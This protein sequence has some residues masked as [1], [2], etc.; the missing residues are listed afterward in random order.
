M[1][2]LVLLLLST[3]A[4]LA[5]AATTAAGFLAENCSGCHGGDEPE[6]GFEVTGLSDAGDGDPRWESVLRRVAAGQ[7]P[8]PDAGRLDEASTARFIKQVAAA[9]GDRASRIVQAGRPPA[10]RRLTRTEYANAVRDLLAVTVDA[11]ELLPRDEESGGFDNITN[12]GLSPARVA[13]YVAAAERISRTALGRLN[14]DTDGATYRV[15]PNRTQERHVEGLPLGTRGGAVFT[16]NVPVA[17]RYAFRIRLARDR[18]EKVEGLDAV[19]ELDLLIDGRP[20]KRFTVRPPGGGG[21]WEVDFSN[22]DAHLRTETEVAAGPR[23]IGVAFVPRSD[24]LREI[25]RQPFEA[26]YNRH[27]H[28]R[29]SPALYELSVVG[30][31][32]PPTGGLADTPSRRAVF[33][34]LDPTE[35]ASYDEPEARAILSRLARLAFRRPATTDEIDRLTAFYRDGGDFEDGLGRAIAALLVN[36]NFLLRVEPQ[37]DD[38]TPGTAYPLDDFSVAARLSFFLWSSLP[39]GELLDAADAG[40]LQDAEEVSRQASRMLADPRASALV[41]NFADQ[42]LQLRNLAA[43]T[44]DLRAFPDFDDNLRRAMR[45]E[46]QLL[47]EEVV[48]EDRPVTDLIVSDHTFL[49][50][51]LATHYGIPH[52][53]GSH[54]R[55]VDLP[56]D[57][58]RG[59]LLRHAS[60][61]TVTSYATRTS[62]TIR[63]NW[64]LEHILGTPAPPPPPNVPALREKQATAA[65]TVRERL[66]QH[67][68]DPACASCHQLMDP[69]GFALEHFDAVGRH[70]PFEGDLPIDA[71]GTLPDG[72]EVAGIDDLEAAIAARPELFVT[73]LTERLM[74]Y[75]LGRVLA[76][77]D[78]PHV[79]RVVANAAANGN[80]FSA[81]VEGVVRSVPFRMRDAE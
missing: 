62:P 80:R 13:R 74:T 22:A 5:D 38:A 57:T 29:Q 41:T 75:A 2:L 36:P 1:R 6:G 20:V 54:F 9:T 24:S 12:T 72:T 34:P 79:R 60:I 51:R 11:A 10:V 42:W 48:R 16:H 81:I 4:G 67:R 78:G 35:T 33:G 30:P 58:M 61:L 76:A 31:L 64:V 56:E 43:V 65:S 71:A 25:K 15:P 69:I 53:R 32:E 17:G 21:Q 66:A 7:M 40:A 26:S 77:D 3:C 44:P 14:G 45:R 37:P 50:E 63:G 52:V 70:R 73:A 19:H 8:P 46:T 55:R 18:D 47:F 49:N 28:P 23:E 68:S 59:G 39:D 27:R